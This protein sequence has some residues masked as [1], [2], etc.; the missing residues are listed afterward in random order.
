MHI[1]MAEDDLTIVKQPRRAWAV[2]CS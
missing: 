1:L 2:R